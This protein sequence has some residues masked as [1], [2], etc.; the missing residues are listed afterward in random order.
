MKIDAR[1][2]DGLAHTVE[3]ARTCEEIGVDGAWNS[4][5][6]ADPFLPMVRAAEHS[7][8]LEIG[9]SVA[10]AFARTPMTVAY[11]AWDLQRFAEGRQLV[12]PLVTDDIPHAMCSVGTE[13]EVA[14]DLV[15]RWG[16]LADRIRLNRPGD[17][18]GPGRFEGLVG[19][20]RAAR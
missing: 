7:T 6:R 1:L 3:D 2:R 9:S 19:A 8:R 18:A 5:N 14:A 12:V 11:Q 4:E 20:L 17:T 13:A 15:A 16:S 10:I